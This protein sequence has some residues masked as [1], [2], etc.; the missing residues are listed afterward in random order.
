MEDE[1]CGGCDG[2][3]GDCGCDPDKYWGLIAQAHDDKCPVAY[4]A[5]KHIKSTLCLCKELAAAELAAKIENA[6]DVC[7]RCREWPK[8]CKCGEKRQWL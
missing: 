3:A 2:E 1:C 4:Q 7:Q 5:K 8:D 6:E